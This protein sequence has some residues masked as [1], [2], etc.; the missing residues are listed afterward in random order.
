MNI[1][2]QTATFERVYGIKKGIEL[3]AKAGYE[4]IDFSMFYP[5][6]KGL[7]TESDERIREH[8][9]ELRRLIDSLGIYVYQTHTP[10]PC[11]VA[12]PERDAVIFEAE[13][14][15]FARVVDTRREV[16]DSAS[17]NHGREPLRLARG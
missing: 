13:K 6:D 2:T 3:L 9:G 5:V 14:K 16:R 4:S 15:G 8:F 10:F 11:Y 17:R 12:N 7:L 1:C